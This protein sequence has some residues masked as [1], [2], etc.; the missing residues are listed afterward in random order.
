M[1]AE[2][3]PRPAMRLRKVADVCRAYVRNP[4]P[5]LAGIDRT[6]VAA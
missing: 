1:T 3:P 6:Q 4:H 5:P 2:P